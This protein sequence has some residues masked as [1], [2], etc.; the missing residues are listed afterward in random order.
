MPQ[1]LFA[2][3]WGYLQNRFGPRHTLNHYQNNAMDSGVYDIEGDQNETRIV[4]CGD[5]ATG[6]DEAY[7][8]GRRIT[9][10]KPH[11]TIHLGDVYYVG[12]ITEVQQNFLGDRNPDNNYSPCHFPRGSNGTLAL[13]GNH[14]MYARGNAYFD[15]LLPRIGIKG[16]SGQ[17]ASYFCLQNEHWRVVGLDTGY[18]SVGWPLIELLK[19]PDCRLPDELL[20][21]LD[22]LNLEDDGRGL[23]LLSHHQYYSVYDHCYSAAAVQLS[24]LITKPVLWFWGHE[25]RLVVYEGGSLNGGIKAFG[26]CI[27][28]GGMPI[29][30]PL[31]S[32]FPS[33]S[34]SQRSI[35]FIDTRLYLNNENLRVGVNGFARMALQGQNLRVEYVDVYGDVIF[36]ERWEVRDGTINRLSESSIV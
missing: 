31:P 27:G 11:Y 32:P 26:R 9:E 14:E 17:A 7:H 33:P 15:E 21:W 19:R 23:I 36:L 16:K 6:T 2:F 13:L 35:E 10:S 12:G 8:I 25:H 20:A 28:H 34:L 1:R 3:A 24:K 5:W 4:L 22:K 30:Y 18:N 29:E